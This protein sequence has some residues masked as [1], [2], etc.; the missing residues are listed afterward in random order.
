MKH[1][2]SLIEQNYFKQE[3]LSDDKLE[4]NEDLAKLRAGVL[5]LAKDGCT[6][7]VCS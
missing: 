2:Q 5:V 7:N 6:T 1:N 3:K 4:Q